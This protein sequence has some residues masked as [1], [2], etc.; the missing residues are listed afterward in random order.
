M[1]I[2]QAA[3][4]VAVPAAWFQRSDSGQRI[5]RLAD[6][7]IACVLLSLTFPLMVFVALAIKRESPGPIFERQERRS[8]KQRAGTLRYV[9]PPRPGPLRHRPS[10][11][12]RRQ[13]APIS[14]VK[15]GPKNLGRSLD[16]IDRDPGDSR[17]PIAGP[18]E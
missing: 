14:Q 5:R 17:E 9:G 12:T 8:A 15:N 7:I 18:S 11:G 3:K 16:V 6:L 1:K 4:P 13:R 10:L 2:T